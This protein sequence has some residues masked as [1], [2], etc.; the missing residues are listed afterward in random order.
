MFLRYTS[1]IEHLNKWY[2]QDITKPDG[3]GFK[4]IKMVKKMHEKVA[5]NMNKFYPCQEQPDRVRVSQFEMIIT[6]WTFIG[7]ILILPKKC[8]IHGKNH[9]RRVLTD[10]I[11]L[12][13]AIGYL[14]G[15]SDEFNL[16][17][18]SVDETINLAHLM[19][20]DLFKPAIESEKISKIGK[21]MSTNVIK[22]LN[23]YFYVGS[24]F[25]HF[26]YW[27]EALEINRSVIPRL[28]IRQKIEYQF[29][30]FIFWIPFRFLRQFIGS[31]H[32]DW[33]EKVIRNKH[34]LHQKLKK[35]EENILYTMDE[36]IEKECN[37][38]LNFA[39]RNVGEDNNNLRNNHSIMTCPFS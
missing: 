6:Q 5:Q 12:W 27:Y 22:A 33:L 7:L 34:K 16:C 39:Y 35:R 32:E 17:S 38:K 14:H 37:G 8:G 29:M 31:A 26:V 9:Q 1:T 11:Y 23:Q 13:R 19:Y 36:Y 4:S 15:I 3:N 20:Q 28:T 18:E 25:T 21:K 30:K 2:T 24:G 10:L